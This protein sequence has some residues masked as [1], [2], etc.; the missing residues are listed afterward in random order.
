MIDFGYDSIV[1]EKK[2]YITFAHLNDGS[3]LFDMTFEIASEKT[4]SKSERTTAAVH[5]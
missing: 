3:D 1:R 2:A 4:V 5:M